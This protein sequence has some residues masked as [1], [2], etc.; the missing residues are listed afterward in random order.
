MKIKEVILKTNQLDTGQFLEQKQ[1][2]N[3][4]I[5]DLEIQDLKDINTGKKIIKFCYDM[6][7]QNINYKIVNSLPTCIF[8]PS[9]NMHVEQLRLLKSCFDCNNLFRVS[10]FNQAEFCNGKKAKLIDEYKDKDDLY[11]DFIKFHNFHKIPDVCGGCSQSSNCS[12]GCV[13]RKRNFT[14]PYTKEELLSYFVKRSSELLEGANI[15]PFRRSR[16]FCFPA[17]N[18]NNDCL[19][20]FV[21]G[22]RKRKNPT[23]DFL[24]KMIEGASKE[25]KYINFGGGEP[26]IYKHILELLR[27]A[28]QRGLVVQMFSNGRRFSDKGFTKNVLDTGIDL[29]TEVFHSYKP[30][31]HDFITQRNGSFQQMINGIENLHSL[32]F[33]KLHFMVIIHKQN[34][35]DLKK[36]TEFLLSFRPVRITFEALVLAGQSAKNS[37]VLAIK[38]TE[39]IPFIEEAFELTILKKKNFH[40]VSLPLCLF[41]KKYWKYF[42]NNRYS[43]SAT[44][45]PLGNKSDRYMLKVDGECLAARCIDCQLRKY[46]PGTWSSY[47]SFF[48]DEELLP[49]SLNAENS[50]YLKPREILDSLLNR[51]N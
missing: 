25:F 32:G 39:A 18:C 22:R 11:K 35:R 34:Y 3:R 46:C 30:E 21:V 8:S 26:T 27:L 38:L 41:K 24:K 47:Y 9:E 50:L 33:Y 7:S 4:I 19:Y 16:I 12:F 23:L 10:D 2:E 6:K 17:Y 14:P 43:C 37:D 44:N 28:K 20:C 15:E 40:T 48:G 42:G 45:F 31:T 1:E 13:Y 49:Q 5:F 29:I 51:L 36:M